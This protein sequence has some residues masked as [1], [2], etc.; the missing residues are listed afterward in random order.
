MIAVLASVGFTCS[1]RL[2][3]GIMSRRYSVGV[4]V[5]FPSF[6]FARRALGHVL[7]RVLLTR[8]NGDV[9][10]IF[11][12]GRRNIGGGDGGLLV[13]RPKQDLAGIPPAGAPD[14]EPVTTSLDVVLDVEI[15]REEGA[16]LGVLRGLRNVVP[17][18]EVGESEVPPQNVDVIDVIDIG[19]EEGYID[20][21]SP[22]I[23]REQCIARAREVLGVK[24]QRDRGDRGDQGAAEDQRTIDVAQVL[25]LLRSQDDSISRKALQRLHV[26][27]YHCETERLQS[28]LRAAG[29][30]AKVCNLVPQVVHACQ[31]CRDWK[32]L[33]NS[34]TL[35][36]S[37]AEICNE[38]V[39]LDLMFYRSMLQP[40][41]GGEKGIPICHL[42]E[43]CVRWSACTM[44]KFKS[45]TDLLDCISISWVT[46][47][48]SPEMLTLDGGSGMRAKEVDNWALYNQV[49]FKHKAP[50]QK[51]WLVARHNALIRSALQR[52]E[53]QVIKESLVVS[54]VTVLGL[55]TFMQHSLTS[56][57]SHIPY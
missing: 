20:P 18:E 39:Q 19:A 32:R 14:V 38:E 5:K 56:I 22:V 52:V 23:V 49:T 24:K 44:A 54:S 36:Y 43:C 26:K 4:T 51:L 53:S 30:P 33:G 2:T 1:T 37:L 11:L 7:Q 17:K 47:I 50:H 9:D 12:R 42:I 6:G 41:F 31:A 46:V 10:F 16:T 15:P 3:P 8:W 48:G 34:N 21:L 29:A 57:N 13:S 27:W 28:P 35:T 40:T 55:V 25:Q 45:T